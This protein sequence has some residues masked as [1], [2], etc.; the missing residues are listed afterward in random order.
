M[1]PLGPG[2][3]LSIISGNER[4]CSVLCVLQPLPP[5]GLGV[6]TQLPRANAERSQE[7]CSTQTL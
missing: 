3:W 7:M 4:H 6:L 2:A 5:W 1:A